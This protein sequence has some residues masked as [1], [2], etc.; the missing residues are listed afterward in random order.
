MNSHNII[1]L[2]IHHCYWV[3]NYIMYSPLSGTSPEDVYPLLH[4]NNYRKQTGLN[5]RD[6]VK[7][8]CFYSLCAI[9]DCRNDCIHHTQPFLIQ[10]NTKLQLKDTAYLLM[11]QACMLTCL[12]MKKTLLQIVIEGAETTVL[13]LSLVSVCL[14][15]PSQM[16]ISNDSC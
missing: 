11:C 10:T 4:F 14:W 1:D 15:E 13:C 8:C 5:C 6:A 16:V 3:R 2:L 12:C 9:T 7:K